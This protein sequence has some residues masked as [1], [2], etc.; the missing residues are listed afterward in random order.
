[1]NAYRGIVKFPDDENGGGICM[2]NT[3]GREA[4]VQPGAN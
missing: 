4:V 2:S 1:M 3:L